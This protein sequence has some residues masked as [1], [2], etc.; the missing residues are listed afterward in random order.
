M[1]LREPGK[2]AG[3]LRFLVKVVV[4]KPRPGMEKEDVRKILVVRIDERLG[5][6]LLTTPLIRAVG[7][8][9]KERDGIVKTLVSERYSSILNGNPY[10]DEVLTFQKRDFFRHPLFFTRLLKR[11]RAEAFD[12][13]I[14]ASHPQVFSRTSA[15]LAYATGAPYRIG[16]D[17]G[18]ARL[19][20]SRP[21]PVLQPVDQ[22]TEA[23]HKR[24]LLHPLHVPKASARMDFFALEADNTGRARAKALDF[25]SHVTSKKGAPGGPLVGLYPGGRKKEQRWPLEHFITL[26]KALNMHN[27]AG[28][29]VFWG[30]GEIQLAEKIASRIENA[31]LAP[32]TDL[33]ELAALI[34]VM[35]VFVSNDTG[36]MHL[37]SALGI[38][39]CGIFLTGAGKRYGPFGPLGRVVDG[40]DGPPSPDAVIGAV[41]D[42]LS[43]RTTTEVKV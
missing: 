8:W 21:V 40:I 6:L 14:D 10:I 34:E 1:A 43:S 3:F 38:P 16:H 11:L 9:A 35:D 23:E 31:A 12:A 7:R 4:G 13:V 41:E 42:L 2:G 30:P 33:L 25:L 19:F 26:G 18:A 37:S 39:V 5:D 17:R 32:P 20:F 29:V 27:H 24:T 22:V 36:P 15:L 28:L